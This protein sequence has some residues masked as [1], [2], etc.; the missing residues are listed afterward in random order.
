MGAV[1][2]TTEPVQ[3]GGK[4]MSGK[5]YSASTNS[6]EAKKCAYTYSQPNKGTHGLG[7]VE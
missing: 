7:G 1:C 6:S 3:K 2:Q 5:N 4:I